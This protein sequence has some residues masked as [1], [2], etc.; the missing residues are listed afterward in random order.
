MRLIVICSLLLCLPYLCNSFQTSARL[1]V[2]SRGS[3]KMMFEGLDTSAFHDLMIVHKDS[4][5]GVSS[6]L[7]SDEA[8][9]VYTKIDK[10]GFIGSIATYIE[11]AI[12]LFQ[13]FFNAAGIKN[14]YGPAIILFTIIGT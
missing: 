6:W 11:I 7:L 1:S 12:D 14:G 5:S 9:S 4:F 10:T 3:T 2:R 13:R 8:V